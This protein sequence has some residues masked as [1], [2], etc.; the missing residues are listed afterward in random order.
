MT[1]PLNEFISSIR[2]S[3]SIEQERF[4]I[5]TEQA[6]I[7]AYLRKCDPLIRPRVI[8]K[9]VFLE[10]IGQNPAWGQMEAMT[11]MCDDQFSFKR[12]GYIGA[13]VLLDETTE[14]TVLVTQTLLKDLSSTDP[15][16]QS[17][18]L[19][20][21][22]NV[23][24]PEVCRA[25]ASAVQK[26]IDSNNA[27]VMKR[28]GMAIVRIVRKNPDLAETFKNSVQKLLNHTNHGVVLSGMNM[29]ISL[30]DVEPRLS[31]LWSQFAGPFTRI[32]KSLSNSRGTREYSFG[33]FNDPYMQMKAMHA[34]SLLKK[35]TEELDGILQSIISST[36]TRRNTGRALLYQAVELVVAVSTN[37]SL[38]GLAF[39]QVGRLLSMKDPNVLYS[40]LSVFARVLY[41]ERE[42]INRGSVDTQAL[43]R[44]KKQIV[45]CLDHRDP[46]V[47]RRALDVISALIDENNVESLIPE[48]ITFI[49]L[50]D[51][52]FRMELISKIYSAVQ[53]FA[54]SKEWNFDTVHQI[55]VDSGN[56]VSA[57]II[58]DFCDLIAR[59]PEI[60]PHAVK[61]LLSSLLQFSDNQSLMQISA[62]VIGEFANSNDGAFDI[63]KQIIFLPQTAN[64][65]KF[66][67]I[68]ALGK[69]S[70]RIGNKEEAI[71][72][73]TQLSTS[74]NLEVQQRAGEMKNILSMDD[75]CDEFLAPISV[76]NNEESQNKLA[77]PVVIKEKP[78]DV[79]DLLLIAMD[80]PST[81]PPT[82]KKPVP[83]ESLLGG[84]PTQVPPAA[85]KPAE[86]KAPNLP[87][88]LKM[89]DFIIYGQ[90]KPN[91]SNPQQI[92][93]KLFIAGTGNKPLNEFKIEFQP[94]HGWKIMAQPADSTVL[95]AAG[96]KP[97]SQLLY[98][99]NQTQAPF[100]IQI[101]ASYRYGSQPITETGVIREL[102]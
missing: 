49:R 36:E 69:L 28:A 82:T 19:A 32:L 67:V 9:L 13:S 37:T 56:Y 3:E 87:E 88:L 17:L 39:N 78:D 66:Y 52:D 59:T 93:L 71:A 34:L 84:I 20:F 96:G 58:K 14:L 44:Y 31:K 64:E 16:I 60:Q 43:Q 33:V 51:S 6:H 10:I 98:L 70:V 8:C 46:S 57:D 81:K 75:Y 7:R 79:D 41:T 15:N 72:L 54:P 97:I 30:I 22:S 25:C 18:A 55:L 21:I 1:Q 95:E 63:L 50:A 62:F 45:R 2:L 100:A 65:T 90:S 5:A 11:L 26:T 74:N 4:L 85:P 91:P 23:G 76:G 86:V 48:I 92:A 12:I 101:K 89:P 47:R 27:S 80:T 53:R 42:I 99:L 35:P 29:V 24:S 83:V 61:Q 68:M 73:M 94:S 38:R 40:A 102:K 77:A